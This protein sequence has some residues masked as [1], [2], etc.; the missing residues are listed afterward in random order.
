[1]SCETGIM[2]DSSEDREDKEQNSFTMEQFDMVKTVGTG[3][4]S[5]MTFAGIF[6]SLCMF[7]YTIICRFIC[8]DIHVN[9]TKESSQ[10]PATLTLLELPENRQSISLLAM[11]RSAV[12]SHQKLKMIS[13]H[14]S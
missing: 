1:M 13:T 7:L 12:N 9:F 2:E 6:A 3:E 5:H 4:E 11:P 10:T 8:Q 14:K